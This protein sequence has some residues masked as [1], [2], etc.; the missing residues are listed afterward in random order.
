MAWAPK[1]HRTTMLLNGGGGGGGGSSNN[2]SSSNG[3]KEQVPFCGMHGSD[4][5]KWS[6]AS[7]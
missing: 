5:G 3:V 7:S 2:S 4:T 1:E 6:R